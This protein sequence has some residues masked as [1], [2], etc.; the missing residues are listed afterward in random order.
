MIDRDENLKS[1]SNISWNGWESNWS[2][3][4]SQSGF[5]LQIESGKVD[6]AAHT[7]DIVGLIHDQ[8]SFD[9]AVKVAMDFAEKTKKL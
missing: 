5:V 6:W 9:E 8:N 2:N 4:R 7:N 1:Y 3:E